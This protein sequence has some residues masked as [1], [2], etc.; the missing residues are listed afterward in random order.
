MIYRRGALS[1][2]FLFLYIPGTGKKIQNN[3]MVNN[4]S[5]SIGVAGRMDILIGKRYL[6]NQ[7]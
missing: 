6:N 4:C 3:E 5:D 1:S 2:L 7:M